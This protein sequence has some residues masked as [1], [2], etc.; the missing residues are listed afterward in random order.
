MCSFINREAIV[1]PWFKFTVVINKCQR[2]TLYFR[3]VLQLIETFSILINPSH[4]CDIYKCKAKMNV[5]ENVSNYHLSFNFNFLN[6]SSP[7]GLKKILCK[8]VLSYTLHKIFSRQR[9][10]FHSSSNLLSKR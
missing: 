2:Q 10:I 8:N 4:T 1:V 7:E 6:V 3:R 9:D 5:H